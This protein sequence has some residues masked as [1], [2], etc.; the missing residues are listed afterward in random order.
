VAVIFPELRDLDAYLLITNVSTINLVQ[1]STNTTNGQDGTWTTIASN[2]A[3]QTSTATWRTAITA[4]TALAVLA[5]RFYLNN[6]SSSWTL[7]SVHLYGEPAPGSNPDRLVFWDAVADNKM[8]PAT[9]DWGN[10]PRS[11]SDDRTVRVKN[12]S[13]TKTA[14]NV[15]VSFD[16][17]NDGTPTVP[18]QH[19][20]SYGGGAFLA[21]VNLGTLAPGAIS[22]PITVRRVTPSSAQLGLFAPRISAVADTFA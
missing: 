11:S 22:G 14:S 15:R 13:A 19:L 7:R 18:G 20:V 8:P 2:Y 21:Q 17:L 12:L 4:G 6:G 9:L 1:T 16:I 3:T 10:V 5:I